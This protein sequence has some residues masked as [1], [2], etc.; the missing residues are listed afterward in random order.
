MRPLKLTLE[1]FG[2]YAQRQEVDFAALGAHRLF[3]ICGPTGAGKTSLL[4]AICFA[5]FG[6]SSGEERAPGHL[7]SLHAAPD[8]ATEVIFDFVQAG[9]HWRIRRSPAWERPK[10][11]GEGTTAERMK[12][13]LSELIAGTPGPP[14]ERDAEVQ[15]RIAG[16]LGLKAAE[17]R[18]VVLLPQGRF[19]EVLTAEP[20]QRQE[21]LRTLFRT[22]L[23]ERVQRELREGASA[24]RAALREAETTL[25]T[26]L[27]QAGGATLAEAEA[28]RDALRQARDTAEV[29]RLAAEQAEAAAR[30]AETTGLDTARRLD[31]AAKAQAALDAQRARQPEVAADRAQLEAARRADRLRGLLVA[32]DQARDEA[33]RETEER[34][35]ATQRLARAT[36]ALAAAEAALADSPARDA[37][38]TAAQAE[39]Q[40]LAALAALAIEAEVA[41][42]QAADRAAD[43]MQ[44]ARGLARAE[45]AATSAQIAADAAAATLD[46]Q[47]KLAAQ[48]P[49][50]ALLR[51]E[52]GR[53]LAAGNAL[54]K[55]VIALAGAAARHA[56]EATALA[57]A[58][59]EAGQARAAR[60]A[61][62]AALAADHAAAL[63]EALRPGDPCPVCGSP[64]HPAPAR[65]RD[66]G[67]PDLDAAMQAEHAAETRRDAARQRCQQAETALRLAEQAEATARA[68]L[69]E[70]AENAEAL[71]TAATDAETAL[72]KAQQAEAR[73][74]SC[75]AALAEARGTQAA[76]QAALTAAKRA[77]DTARI[78]AAAA[79]ATRDERR[80]QLP[81][82]AADAAT[83]RH[84]A[85]A[86]KRQAE[87]QAKALQQDRDARS[88]AQAEHAAR[89]EAEAGAASRAAA[90]EQRRQQ[91]FDAL[92]EGARREGFAT[93]RDLRA[94]L[95]DPAQQ[96]ALAAT[97]GAFERDL[98]A[99][100]D[101]AARTAT[102][103]AG[104]AAPDLATLQA[105]H[106]AAIAGRQAAAEAAARA[107]EQ[108]AA[109][110]QLLAQVIA[111]ATARDAAL[112][113]HALR[114]DLSDLANGDG[115][116]LNFE[117]YVLSG[118]LD[119]ALEAANRRLAAML[120]GRY[121]I[122]R[123]EERERANAAA[124]LDIEVLDRWNMQPR[125][126]ATLSG[127]E[128]F[129]ASLALAL[130]LA[131]TVA[132][133]AGAQ[134][135][136][137]L[138]V[139]EGFG[140]LDPETLDTAIGVLEGLQAGDRMVGVISHVAE[141][142]ERIPARLEVTAGRAGSRAT[143]RFG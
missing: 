68:A 79:A 94:A 39:A 114:Q 50:R 28:A 12:V 101:H 92:G 129:C 51:D 14:V 5:L 64:H 34:N 73:L 54:A 48:R 116:G 59:T 70:G 98:A 76:A 15:S 24:A 91:G 106:Q 61:A 46:A 2:P 123:R 121:A 13:A 137:A 82:G 38:I 1:G 25:R 83:L 26:L 55:A 112:A 35:D 23:Y 124:G 87:D 33:Q 130:G 18:Q 71:A 66:A 44:A 109:R 138:F 93:T 19:R 108:L 36:E 80:R 69:G 117:G 67:L 132:A 45:A 122:R 65:L 113:G 104:L 136:D 78:A 111:A 20:K 142:Q 22:A 62:A 135:L 9:R 16:I 40:R 60:E 88:T 105:A 86:A 102:Q 127:G 131:E 10:Q 125:P 53:R 120:D 42:Q 96:D 103:A 77:D 63:A 72:V 29:A 140:S 133:H 7:R 49:H 89:S 4:D 115:T 52:A 75:R 41:A 97:I 110:E 95:L 32:A 81:E 31:A 134:Q 84:Q 47:E 100:E 143:F 119:E 30:M 118:L 58:T 99:L 8:R 141:L 37:A 90:A 107:A 85:A 57:A 43:A 3:L 74:P 11:R 126:A 139:D 21:I 6:E 17:F 27:G 56:R 128:G